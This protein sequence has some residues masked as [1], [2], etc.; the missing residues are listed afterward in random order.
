MTTTAAYLRDHRFKPLFTDLLGWEHA[1]GEVAVSVDG[2]DFAFVSLAHKRGLQVLCCATD[3]VVLVS[4][5]LLRKVQR[6]VAR[7]VHEH[8]LIFCCEE[9]RKQVWQWAIQLPDGRKLRHREHP[10]FSNSPP[11]PFLNRLSSLR[12]TVDEEEKVTL[13]DALDRVRQVLDTT[14]EQKLFVKRPWY[15]A[16]SDELARAMQNGDTE[17]FHRFVV[18]HLKLARKISK[19]LC[20]WFGML[21]EDAEQIGFLGVMRAARMFRPELGYQFSTFAT[22]W[23]KQVCQRLGPEFALLIRLPQHVFWPCFRLHLTLENMVSAVGPA[24]VRLC[25]RELERRDPKAGKRLR[26]FQRATAIE[27]LSD[28][29]QPEFHAARQIAEGRASP[30]DDLVRAEQVAIVQRNLDRLPPREAHVLRLRYGFDDF[31]NKRWKKSATSSA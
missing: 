12:F 31:R 30:L 17:S 8:I 13:V 10:F 24:G 15:A 6:L 28:R 20:R 21:P 1:S 3:R 11:A 7:T 18:F 27:S 19:R 9:P 4:R 26:A 2:R 14:A 23:I 22:P 25:L 16:R 5:T 29:K